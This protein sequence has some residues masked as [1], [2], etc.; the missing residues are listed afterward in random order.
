[1]SW[2]LWVVILWVIGCYWVAN[3]FTQNNIEPS[4]LTILIAMLPIVN[5]LFAIAKTVVDIKNGKHLDEINKIKMLF[6]K[7]EQD[8]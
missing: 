5:L 6:K 3:I 8:E 1:M 7:N 4:L 2:I